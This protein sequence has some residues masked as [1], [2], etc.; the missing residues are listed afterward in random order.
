MRKSHIVAAFVGVVGAGW[1]QWKHGVKGNEIATVIM[2][3][4]VSALLW[5]CVL[6]FAVIIRRLLGR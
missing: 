4:T 5:E 2:V 1:L 3:G 6:R